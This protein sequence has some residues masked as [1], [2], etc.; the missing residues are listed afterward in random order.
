MRIMRPI[1]WLLLAL[2]GLVSALQY[3]TEPAVQVTFYMES[4]CPYCR[5]FTTELLG[6]LAQTEVWSIMDLEVVPWVRACGHAH[7]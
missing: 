1:V 6:S 4:L 3:G 2:L 5:Q 7:L